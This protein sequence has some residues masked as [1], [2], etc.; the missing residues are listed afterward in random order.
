MENLKLVIYGQILLVLV[1]FHPHQD[2]MNEE[3]LKDFESLK[4]C[5]EILK[6][7]NIE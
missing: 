7:Q 1:K 2:K 4:H 3:E 6:L 5:A